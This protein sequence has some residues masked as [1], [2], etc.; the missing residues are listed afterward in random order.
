[1]NIKA[2]IVADIE[3]RI[4]ELE[5]RIKAMRETIAELKAQKEFTVN[6]KFENYDKTEEN[7]RD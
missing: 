5:A 2:Q 7:Q 4:A 1:M 6:P 3:Q